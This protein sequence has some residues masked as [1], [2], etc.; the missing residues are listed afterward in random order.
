MN[1]I[2]ILK[3]TEVPMACLQSTNFYTSN[4]TG[5]L[6][7]SHYHLAFWPMMIVMLPGLFRRDIETWDWHKETTYLPLLFWDSFQPWNSSRLVISTLWKWDPGF[8][9][10][11][12]KTCWR[13]VAHLKQNLTCIVTSIAATLIG[14]EIT[15]TFFLGNVETHSPICT[16]N[17]CN[18][19]YKSL[20][21]QETMLATLQQYDSKHCL[22]CSM[23]VRMKPG[24]TDLIKKLD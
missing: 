10:H 17:I 4:D 22:L 1:S 18:I 5:W 24:T 8:W 9:L 21:L 19:Q 16:L 12:S 7:Q 15:A 6:P 20:T 23:T 2:E 3:S 11:H 13:W 14:A